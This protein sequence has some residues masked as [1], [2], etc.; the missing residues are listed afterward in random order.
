LGEHSP[1]PLWPFAWPSMLKLG[2]GP[3]LPPCEF[4]WIW[5]LFGSLGILH[6]FHLDTILVGLVIMFWVFPLKS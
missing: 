3:R 1:L 4:T 2:I 5:L 6:N